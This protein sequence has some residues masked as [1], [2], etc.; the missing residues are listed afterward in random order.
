M[1]YMIRFFIFSILAFSCQLIVAQGKINR[2]Y[3][4]PSFPISTKLIVSGS[5]NGPDYVDLGLPS[6]RRWATC[7]IGPQS[8]AGYGEYFSWA[9]TKPKASYTEANY[10][11]CID[12]YSDGLG[13]IKS[14]TI[15][16]IH[17]I[18][19]NPRFDAARKS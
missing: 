16:A 9:E 18:I 13:D 4:P 11:R 19:D 1:D 15:R 7:N 2:Q 6:G 10:S 5:I 12:I 8:P 3:Q 17:R 14:D